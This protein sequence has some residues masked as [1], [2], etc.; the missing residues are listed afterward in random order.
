MDRPRNKPGTFTY[1]DYLTW[2][3]NER[4]ELIDGETWNMSPAPTPEYQILV[5]NIFCKIAEI[6]DDR[7]CETYL[8]PFDVRLSEQNVNADEETTTVVQPD[9]SVFYN[10]DLIDGRFAKPDYYRDDESI[11]SVILNAD[12]ALR[13][14]LPLH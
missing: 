12:F 10:P 1:A 13:E 3:E 9:I 4:W 5:G 8:S 14:V 6:T 7:P 11:H 2:P